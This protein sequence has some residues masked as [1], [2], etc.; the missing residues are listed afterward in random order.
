MHLRQP[1]IGLVGNLTELRIPQWNSAS[2]L[3]SLILRQENAN[4]S[5][6]LLSQNQEITRLTK[7]LDFTRFYGKPIV[8]WRGG[9]RWYLIVDRAPGG[10]NWFEKIRNSHPGESFVIYDKLPE[11][12]CDCAIGSWGGV[13]WWSGLKWLLFPGIHDKPA[14]VE[15]WDLDICSRENTVISYCSPWKPV[16]S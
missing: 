15:V 5:Q 10:H 7:A 11:F 6:E 4:L 9:S 3:G 1:R 2:S 12:Y 8:S 13:G 14:G 16:T